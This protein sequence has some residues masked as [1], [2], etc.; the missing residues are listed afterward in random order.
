MIGL[1]SELLFR[2][3]DEKVAEM[4]LETPSQLLEKLKEDTAQI[5]IQFVR[6]HSHSASC[7]VSSREEKDRRFS[8]AVSII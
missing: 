6:L 8:S 4:V 7:T 5:F 2:T 3:D 1:D